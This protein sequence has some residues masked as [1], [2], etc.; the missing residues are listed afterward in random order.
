VTLTFWITKILAT[1]FRE[2]AG[3]FVSMSLNLGYDVGL[4]ITFTALIVILS[5]RIGFRGLHPAIF[6]LGISTSG[7]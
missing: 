1:T 4:A 7:S 6:W 2:T 5:V 3:D